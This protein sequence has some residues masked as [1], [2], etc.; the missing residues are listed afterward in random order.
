MT[1]WRD[2]GVRY[3]EALDWYDDWWLW[4]QMSAHT[5]FLHVRDV[6]AIYRLGLSESGNGTATTRTAT[7]A[8]W[9]PATRCSRAARRGARRWRRAT[10]R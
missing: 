1:L 7:R 4:L 5:A 8:C 6:T 3:D 9:P 2:D 10:R